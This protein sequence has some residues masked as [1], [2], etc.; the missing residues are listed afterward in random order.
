MDEVL[1]P[2]KVGIT[3][4]RHSILPPNIFTQPLAT[5]VAHVE[6]RIGK[7]EVSLQVFM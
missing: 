7:D 2:G 4:R 3:D 1:H 5:P 6:R